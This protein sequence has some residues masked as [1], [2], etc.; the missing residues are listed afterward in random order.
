MV[1]GSSVEES[2]SWEENV[3]QEEVEGEEEEDGVSP[4][5]VWGVI[6]AAPRRN[7]S[8]PAILKIA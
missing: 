2:S 6:G 1:D 5:D 4:F 3:K 8:S 7:V